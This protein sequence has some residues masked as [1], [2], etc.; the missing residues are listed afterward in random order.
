MSDPEHPYDRAY[1]PGQPYPA[2]QPYPAQD[3]QPY[4]PQGH[5]YAVPGGIP[6]RNGFGITALVLALV[7]LAVAVV[8]FTEFLAIVFGGL[9]VVCGLL[10]LG[11]ARSGQ[12]TNKVMAIV[13]AVLGLIAMVVGA[14]ATV[15][16]ITAA[17]VPP[18]S[19]S[20]A[21]SGAADPTA[22]TGPAPGTF[23]WENGLAVEVSAPRAVTF[24]DTACCRTSGHGIAF[25]IHLINNTGEV[26]VPNAVQTSLTV[27]GVAAEQVVDI[28]RSFDALTNSI[29]PGLDLTVDIAFDATGSDLLLTIG[30]YPYDPALFTATL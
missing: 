24:S 12:A 10:G 29:P 16:V 25:T 20:T 27:D 23:T 30:G 28:P 3:P 2:A 26:V 15:I 22:Q 13:G 7:G 14:T 18:H 8:P 5:P 11:R 4:D 21:P 19:P 17:P 9:A 6:P 1:R